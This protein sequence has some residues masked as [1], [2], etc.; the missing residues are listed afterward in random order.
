MKVKVIAVLLILNCISLLYG[1]TFDLC[2]RNKSFAGNALS[3][4]IYMQQTGTT[5]LFLGHS[6][7]ALVFNH[8]C[9]T[10]PTVQVLTAAGTIWNNYNLGA[11]IKDD[12]VI[13]YNVGQPAFSNQTEFDS[14]I[15]QVSS[16]GNGTLIG[17]IKITGLTKTGNATNLRWIWNETLTHQ[18]IVHALNNAADWESTD[19]TL[20]ANI[21]YRPDLFVRIFLQGAF[22]IGNGNMV[23]TLNP[24]YL[25]EKPPYADSLTATVAGIPDSVVD[26]L[27]IEFRQQTDG[28]TVGA[29]SVFI[30]QNGYVF[31]L[32]LDSPGLALDLADGSYYI[33]LHQRNHLSVMSANP[34]N[35]SSR[36][37]TFDFTSNGSAFYGTNGGVDITGAGVWGMIAGET[38]D[39][40]IVTVADKAPVVDKLNEAG[41]YKADTNFTGIVTVA[42]KAYIVKN[43]NKASTVPVP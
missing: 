30:G 35:L 43:L 34:V 33:V 1:Q 12:S 5:D 4:D 36:A 19:I 11:A 6:D 37:A 20:N 16:G 21:I 28:P 38:N 8:T 27:N 7:F 22:D 10:S 40:G 32:Q 29:G 24:T 13:V 18:T 3:F 26:Y 42:D 39:T 23:T 25:P 2:V 9:F 14:K 31:S 15:Q 17:Q 41:Y